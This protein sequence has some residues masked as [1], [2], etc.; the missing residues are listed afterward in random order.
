M[1]YLSFK[2]IQYIEEMRRL[3]TQPLSEDSS[4]VVPI[5][6]CYSSLILGLIMGFFIRHEKELETT[7]E[8]WDTDNQVEEPAK[9]TEV[10][11]GSE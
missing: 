11:L 1:G 5:T 4:Q 3:E 10:L 8:L 9:K 6:G 7:L 2:D